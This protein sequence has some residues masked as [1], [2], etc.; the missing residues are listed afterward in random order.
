MLYYVG[1]AFVIIYIKQVLPRRREKD[2]GRE[3]ERGRVQEGK[4]GR[5][6]ERCGSDGIDQRN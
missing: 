2:K 1:I 6:R 5:E 3:E 4:R